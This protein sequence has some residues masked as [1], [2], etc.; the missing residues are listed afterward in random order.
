MAKRGEVAREKVKDTIISAFGSNFVDIQDK[1][2]YVQAQDGSGEMIQFAI[3][4]TMPKTPIACGTQESH[5]WTG[6][7]VSPAP[8]QVSA[9]ASAKVSAEDEEKIAKL[10]KQLGIEG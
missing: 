5:D 3:A 4:I 10:M 7:E 6:N 9:P 1:K 2:I 8:V